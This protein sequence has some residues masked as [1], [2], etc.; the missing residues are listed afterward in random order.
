MIE[1]KQLQERKEELINH[2]RRNGYLKSE[3]VIRAFRVV[4]RENF[5]GTNAKKYAYLDR[6]LPILSN[7]TISAP[8]MVAM[9]VSKDIFD[10]RVGDIC[11]EVGAG[12]GYHA[13]VIAEIVAPSN[14]DKSLWG[15]VYTIERIGKLVQFARDNL[16]NTGYSERVT[17]IHGDGSLG[18]PEKAPYDRITVAAAAP[19]IPPPLIEQLKP[20]GKLV[21]PVGNKG[22]YQELIIVQKTDDGKI[23]TKS[24]CGVAFV[25]LIGKHGY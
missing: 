22:F 3:E 20:N 19:S 8:H 23:V 12:S 10:L 24:V 9:M 18:Y 4:P 21:I 25:P 7:Q 2:Y 11:L 14:V 13:A 15:H 16:A 17:V 6:P 5:I 1:E